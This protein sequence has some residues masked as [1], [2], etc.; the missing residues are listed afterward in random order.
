MDARP[1]DEW[2][3]YMDANYLPS[4]AIA[5]ARLHL[6]VKEEAQAFPQ[7]ELLA[8]THKEIAREL[9]EEFLNVW[10]ENH[11]PNSQSGEPTFTCSRLAIIN[12]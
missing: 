9:V 3:K 11:D 8:A 12:V 2:L 5:T 6:R 7:I 10:A 1:S 4:L